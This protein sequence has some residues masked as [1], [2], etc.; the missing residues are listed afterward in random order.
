M[1]VLWASVFRDGTGYAHAAIEGALACEAAGLDVVCRSITLS[2]LRGIAAAQ[3]IAHLEAKDLRG[4]DAVIQ[5]SLPHM[6][7]RKGGVRN[8]GF[9]AWETTH[10]RKSAWPTYCNMLDEI[11]TFCVQARQAMIDSGVQVPIK[12]IPHACDVSRFHHRPEPL[13]ISALTG[14][15][16]FYAIGDF[17]RRKNFAGLLRAYFA[18]F[19]ARDPVALLIKTNVPGMTAQRGVQ[20]VGG[21]IAELK[22]GMRLYRDESLYPPVV[23]ITDYLSEEMLDRLHATGHC[24]VLP[25]HG[26]SWCIPA[27]DAMGFG[28]PIIVSNWGAFPDMTHGCADRYFHANTQ[29]YDHTFIDQGQLIPGSLAPCFAPDSGLGDLY[30]GH[31][32]WFDPD[33]DDLC[34][35][36]RQSY[37]E[38][39]GGVDW[40]RKQEAAKKRVAAFSHQNV[41]QIIRDALGRAV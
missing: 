6:F 13:A 2:S 39:P 15:M 28:N 8:I 5:M 17:V 18:T 4:V 31:E 40:P 29:T 3:R 41:G 32:R 23:V 30:T 20:H 11:W 38:W 34:Q 16:V 37:S 26:E 19:S 1:K 7:E 22:R 10:F 27:M 35:R 21:I 24:F 9:F 25:S 33:L 14:K 36:L 12:V